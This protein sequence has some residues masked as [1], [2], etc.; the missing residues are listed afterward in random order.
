MKTMRLSAHWMS[1]LLAVALAGNLTL[2]SAHA[3]ESWELKDGDRVVLLGNTLIERA[4]SYDY[5]ETALIAAHPQQNITFRN[6]GWSGDNVFGEARAGFGTVADGF[7]HLREHVL[8]LKPTVI[9][10]GYGE[11]EAYAGER[12]LPG[13][14]EGLAKLLEVL[15]QTQARI[16][17]ISPLR[18]ENLGKPLPDPAPQ[19]EKLQLYVSALKQVAD[20]RGYGFIDLFSS[21][22]GRADTAAPA[23]H[24]TDNGIHLTAFGYWKTAPIIVGAAKSSIPNWNVT[25][26]DGEVRTS[27][28]LQLS[29]L[30]ADNSHV[31]FAAVAAQLPLPRPRTVE[32]SAGDVT[33]ASHETDLPSLRIADL[34]PGPYTLKVD[35]KPVQTATAREWSRGVAL[36]SG[37]DFDQAEKLRQTILRKNQLYFYRWRPQNITYLLGFRKHEQG[38]NAREIPQFDPLV[39]E[40]EVEI[41][42][43]RQP[44]VHT[45]ELVPADAAATREVQP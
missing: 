10:V 44:T 30:K 35:G 23:R 28:G 43:L 20:E 21:P 26:S 16:V 13:F 18:H 27:D 7:N 6:L 45:Y 25:I 19:N 24:L 12:G 41:A 36:T 32:N 31:K 5:W 29:E 3:A 2:S 11:N 34:K 39:A 42:K 22:L 14:L 1:L 9:L 4:Q 38:N 33:A 40:L 37:P 15:E 8:S 17:L